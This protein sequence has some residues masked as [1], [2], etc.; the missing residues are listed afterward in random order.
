MFVY[1]FFAIR[2]HFPISRYGSGSGSGQMIPIRLDP[3]PQ[4]C[5]E[6]QQYS[7]IHVKTMSGTNKLY[8]FQLMH[9]TIKSF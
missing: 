3:D 4:N 5:W 2:I 8:C 7:A 1:F 9:F 6:G